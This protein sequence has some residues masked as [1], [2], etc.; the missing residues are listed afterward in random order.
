[1]SVDIQVDRL[2]EFKGCSMGLQ[3]YQKGCMDKQQTDNQC[4]V[5][6][7][8]TV[9]VKVI[10]FLLRVAACKYSFWRRNWLET[11]YIEK[12]ILIQNC[13]ATKTSLMV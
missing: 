9:F 7:E 4:I 6:W 12:E 8:Y 2:S 13:S 1:M 11:V 3:T 10:L 5:D